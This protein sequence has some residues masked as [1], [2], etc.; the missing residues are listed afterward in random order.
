MLLSLF[1]LKQSSAA[2]TIVKSRYMQAAEKT[3]LSKVISF[4]LMV[5]FIRHIYTVFIGTGPM[6]LVH[7]NDKNNSGCWVLMLHICL[8]IFMHV[9]H[10]DQS[11]SLTNESTTLPLRPSSPKPSGLKTKFGTPPR[12]SVAPQTAARGISQILL[13]NIISIW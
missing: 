4:S 9:Y 11:N 8:F 1:V 5:F 3:S 13:K 12:R 10:H 2:G 6:C 7:R